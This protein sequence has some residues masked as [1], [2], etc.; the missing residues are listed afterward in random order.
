MTS[1]AALDLALPL[2]P[3]VGA[4]MRVP[5]VGGGEARAVDLDIAATAPALA[6]VAEHVTRV[7]P[8]LGSVHRGAGWRSTLATDAYEQAR[9]V[10]ADFV[11]ARPSDQVVFTR[12]TTEAINLLA[13]AVPGSVLVLD[14]EHHANLLPWVRAA[15]GC[16]VV[17][18]GGTIAATLDAVEAALR[19]HRPALLA[20]TGASNVSG[21]VL[22]L[23]RLARLPHDAG[24]PIAVDGAQLVPHRR[25][26]LE[27]ADLDYLA[28][29]G[30]KAYAPFGA[31]A[32]VGRADWLEQAA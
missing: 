31:G 16:R 14:I 21:E 7:L 13:A 6:V 1:L 15:G 29:S 22:P 23:A 11:G 2:L 8:H 24:A 18:A 27:V 30:H 32:L 9:G 12:N 17:R 10:V 25:V 20:V 5:L 4:D 19:L 3:V 28:F 26:D